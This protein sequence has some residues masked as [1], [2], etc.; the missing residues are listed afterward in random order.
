MNLASLLWS[1]L[2]FISNMLSIVASN[3]IIRGN[4]V[5]YELANDKPIKNV[6]HSC[7]YGTS[8]A[9]HNSSIE[10]T[11]KTSVGSLDKKRENELVQVQRATADLEDENPSL[12]LSRG[13]CSKE[14]TVEVEHDENYENVDLEKGCEKIYEQRNSLCT[15]VF[16][17]KEKCVHIYNDSSDTQ[18]LESYDGDGDWDNISQQTLFCKEEELQNVHKTSAVS[19]IMVQIILE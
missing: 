18:S 7:E 14:K 19:S 5:N 6:D 16:N 9:T 3:T 1:D 13:F 12:D 15:K 8:I 10:G 4:S 2:S 11:L 17:Q